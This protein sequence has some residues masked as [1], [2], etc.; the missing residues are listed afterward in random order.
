MKSPQFDF[1]NLKLGMVKTIG[2][3]RKVNVILLSIK[4]S[5][6]KLVSMCAY[7]CQQIIKIARKY[8]EL[9]QEYCNKF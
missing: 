1:V 3:P 6:T 5:P 2:T 4:I 8:N 7:N 9:K